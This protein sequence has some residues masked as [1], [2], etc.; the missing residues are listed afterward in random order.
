MRA[1]T[2]AEARVT[3]AMLA[4]AQENERER[5]R[6]I[7]LP[8][9][10]YHAVRARIYAEGWLRDRYL[11]NP[12][13]LGFPSATFALARP[14]AEKADE[15]VRRWH[16]EPGTVL[17]WRGAQSVLSVAF[18]QDAATAARAAA[19]LGGSGLTSDITVLTAD[20]REPSVPVYF[21]YEGLWTHMVD[22]PG[23]TSYPRGLGGNAIN[24]NRKGVVPSESLRRS[25]AE[26][27]ARP[28]VAAQDGRPGHLMGPSS[29][30]RSLRRLVDQGWVERRIFPDPGLLPAYHGRTADQIVLI[31][32]ELVPNARGDALLALLTGECR[33]YPF[34]F[35]T[36]GRRVLIGSLG[37]SPGAPSTVPGVRRPVLPSLQ[38]FLEGI[39]IVQEPAGGLQRILDHRYD[40][41]IPALVGPLAS[42]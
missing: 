8:R 4:A 23:V 2:D 13:A 7:Q 27:L 9:S 31:R 19:R 1:L 6:Q 37:Q 24:P 10:T 20:F 15:L 26:I 18:H 16:D 12:L 41:L 40:R 3:A 33:V 21:D 14:F 36:Q 39:E 38:Q 5:L 22:L 25:A 30:P 17:L 35:V 42:R 28:F 29:L 11:P 34:L 32:G